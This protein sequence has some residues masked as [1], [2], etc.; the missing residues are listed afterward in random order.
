MEHPTSPPFSLLSLYI[1]ISIPILFL[2]VQILSVGHNFLH[3]GL[4]PVCNLL[5]QRKK[6]FADFC[7]AIFNL[8]LW[9]NNHIYLFYPAEK[10]ETGSR[11]YEGID[12]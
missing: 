4:C 7:K 2:A 12:S 5:Y 11:V 10:K 6:R 8:N 9:R 1:V 3:V